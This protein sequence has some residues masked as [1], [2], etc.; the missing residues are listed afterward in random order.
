MRRPEYGQFKLALFG[1]SMC[2]F[3]PTLLLFHAWFPIS[4]INF[5]QLSRTSNLIHALVQLRLGRVSIHTLGQLFLQTS[6]RPK[7]GQIHIFFYKQQLQPQVANKSAQNQCAECCLINLT[8]V[9]WSD[10]F[11]KMGL[12][13]SDFSQ[14]KS[15]ILIWVR[16]SHCGYRQF[17]NYQMR[18]YKNVGGLHHWT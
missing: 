12:K 18:F 10:F 3:T 5:V 4:L 9:R 7:V 11:S 14:K 16:F 2:D 8:K 6:V 17:W 1:T 13:W 15:F